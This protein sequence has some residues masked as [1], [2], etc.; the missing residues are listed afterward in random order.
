MSHFLLWKRTTCRKRKRYKDKM[1]QIRKIIETEMCSTTF[2]VPNKENEIIKWRAS[3]NVN[4]CESFVSS[5]ARK[6]F[7]SGGLRI[8][9][10]LCIVADLQSSRIQVAFFW[11]VKWRW[12]F[13]VVV[14]FWVSEF[15]EISKHCACA[16]F[17]ALSL[18][19]HGNNSWALELF[20]ITKLR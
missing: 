9:G 12:N 5:R 10:R 16:W 17:C 15:S 6:E 1:M 2:D 13:D 7:L 8:S 19:K 20:F 3:N 4:Y 18:Q 11:N 14:M